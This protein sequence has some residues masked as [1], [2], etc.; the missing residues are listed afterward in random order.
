MNFVLPV[1][2]FFFLK[3]NLDSQES[4]KEAAHK[5]YKRL[6]LEMQRRDK[7]DKLL[8]KQRLRDK[9]YKKKQRGRTTENEENGWT[10][11]VNDLKSENPKEQ[12][13]PQKRYFSNDSSDESNGETEK[14]GAYT[15]IHNLSLSTQESLALRMLNSKS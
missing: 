9:R 5:R 13:F 12:L 11:E 8:E 4:L 3:T 1:Y 7:E 15:A 10:A 2:L 14:R 6:K